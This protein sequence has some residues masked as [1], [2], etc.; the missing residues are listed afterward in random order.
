M[1]STGS[2]R[3]QVTYVRPDNPNFQMSQE[4]GAKLAWTKKYHDVD[5]LPM[6][7]NMNAQQSGCGKIT[8]IVTED[9]KVIAKSSSKGQYSIVMSS[10]P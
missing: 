7:W 9:G 10:A 1:K 8:C 2:T 5:S 3:A 6:G 4:T